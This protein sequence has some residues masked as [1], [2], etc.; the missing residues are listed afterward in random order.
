MSVLLLAAFAGTVL[1]A[2]P[3]P[4]ERLVV[5]QTNEFRRMQDLPALERNAQLDAAA[6]ALGAYMARTDRY[7][8]TADGRDADDR[9]QA[10][11]Y[12]PCLVAENIAYQYLST[13]FDNDR[14]ARAFVSGWENSPE[15]RRNMLDADVVDIG[16][17][18]A[19]SAGSGRWYAVQV[20]G[21]PRSQSLQ[22]RIANRSRETVRYRVDGAPFTLP[23]RTTMTHSQ[24]RTPRVTVSRP[25]RDEAT[26]VQPRD[27]ERWVVEPGGALRQAGG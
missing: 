14:L 2:E 8:H 11:G 23:P 10:M 7:G 6:R 1:A 3:A 22:F 26:T 18:V 16:V 17:A 13:G 25:G 5:Q 20:F 4:T 19:Q 9:A 24:C 27:G 12:E 15:H 21:K